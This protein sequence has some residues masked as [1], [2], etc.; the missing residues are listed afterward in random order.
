MLEGSADIRFI[1]VMLGHESLVT[2]QIHTHV[3]ISTLCQVHAQT[4][5]A[6]KPEAEEKKKDER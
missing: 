1:Q 6:G 2:T 5:P 3:S 4:H